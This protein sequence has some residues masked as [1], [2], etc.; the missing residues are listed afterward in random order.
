[1]HETDRK[2]V[3]RR[4]LC[5]RVTLERKACT[6]TD[7]RKQERQREEP[8]CVAVNTHR[9]LVALLAGARTKV[10]AGAA[11]C[12]EDRVRARDPRL[13][14]RCCGSSGAV[15]C[16]RGGDGTRVRVSERLRADSDDEQDER[17]RE[18]PLD[19]GVAALASEGTA[20][21]SHLS[22]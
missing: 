6:D 17:K 2:R 16:G 20:N 22:I 13:R 7:G 4:C 14:A 3:S 11:S 10:G 18:Q 9:H 12:I 21:A 19:E 1:L 15:L 5:C 8:R